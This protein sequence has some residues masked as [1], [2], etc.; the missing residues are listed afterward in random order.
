[1]KGILICVLAFGL[2]IIIFA[3]LIGIMVMG[4]MESSS[5]RERSQG[6]ELTES[7]TDYLDELLFPDPVT[8]PAHSDSYSNIYSDK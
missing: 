3:L 4:V 8:D 1:M 7:D 2:L 6:N 5:K